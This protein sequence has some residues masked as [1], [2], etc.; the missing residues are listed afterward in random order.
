MPVTTIGTYQYLLE[1]LRKARELGFDDQ[2]DAIL[3]EMDAVWFKLSEIERGIINCHARRIHIKII[4]SE[5][6]RDDK[7]N[8]FYVFDIDTESDIWPQVERCIEQSKQLTLK[9]ALLC[10]AATPYYGTVTKDAL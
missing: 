8:L 6:K 7:K 10:D 5:G 3:D 1:K 9:E 4:G 2:E